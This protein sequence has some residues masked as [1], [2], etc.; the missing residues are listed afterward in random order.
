MANRLPTTHQTRPGWL[1]PAIEEKETPR[2]GRVSP[3]YHYARPQTGFRAVRLFARNPSGFRKEAG[4][5]RG[6]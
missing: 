3:R 1:L 4:S 2:A 5:T 6:S